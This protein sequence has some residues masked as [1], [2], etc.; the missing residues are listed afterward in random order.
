MPRTPFTLVQ[1]LAKPRK[2]LVQGGFFWGAGSGP[3]E[4]VWWSDPV[5]T[6]GPP[7]VPEEEVVPWVEGTLPPSLVLV[8]R[9]R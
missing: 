7:C 4:L 2:V 9:G 5:R 1:L 8:G 3:T 6:P